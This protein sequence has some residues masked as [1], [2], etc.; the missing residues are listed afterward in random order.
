LL[1]FSDAESIG[2][3]KGYGIILCPAFLKFDDKLTQNARLMKE[4]EKIIKQLMKKTI[5]AIFLLI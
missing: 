5:I 2:Q 4:K 3:I 1:R